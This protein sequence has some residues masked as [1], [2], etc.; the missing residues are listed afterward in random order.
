[1]TVT[2]I[3][4]FTGRNVVP[5]RCDLN[6]NFRFA[7]GRSLEDA[8][9]EVLALADRFGAA[10]TVTDRAPSGPVILDNPL[11]QEFRAVTAVPVEAKQAWT[12]VAQFAQ[13]GLPAAN[14][15]PGEQAQ[16]HQ[17]GESCGEPALERS[18]AMLERFLRE[19]VA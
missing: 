4:G 15:G 2:R 14:F 17:R 5:A 7:P 10:A 8:E 6:L 12:D 19:A 1:M 16:A 13:A 9:R 18:R 3:E 11:L